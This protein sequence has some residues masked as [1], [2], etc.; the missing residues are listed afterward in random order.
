MLQYFLLWLI[1]QEIM[2]V[3]CSYSWF[4]NC[5][6]LVNFLLP[7]AIGFG[8]VQRSLPLL[9][10]VGVQIWWCHPAASTVMERGRGGR[11]VWGTNSWAGAW[12]TALSF[13]RLFHTE[14]QGAVLINLD[15]HVLQTAKRTLRTTISPSPST[16][17]TFL[18]TS[19][20]KS[21]F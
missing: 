11:R 18:S 9:L 13:N 14:V 21:C 4:S 1:S 15:V 12:H 19:G 8:V 6:D 10:F 17:S 7:L 20:V 16:P 2:S 5:T 3:W